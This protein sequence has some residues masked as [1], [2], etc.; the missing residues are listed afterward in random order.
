[1]V[2]GDRRI[3]ITKD[4]RDEC[5]AEYLALKHGVIEAKENEKRA[6]KPWSRPSRN[7]ST[8]ARTTAPLP[9]ST[10]TGCIRRI[11]SRP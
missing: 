6:S 9:P 8:A 11:P 10:I 2:I 7:T 3:S 1:V 4:T 5:V